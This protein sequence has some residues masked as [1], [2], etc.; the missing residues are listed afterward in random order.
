MSA[1]EDAD[2][3]C[4]AWGQAPLAQQPHRRITP[5]I[6]PRLTV[7]GAVIFLALSPILA[8]PGS[9]PQ[10]FGPPPLAGA[11][12]GAQGTSSSGYPVPSNLSYCGLLGPTPGTAPGLPNY[13]ANITAFWNDLCT[14]P[15]FISVIDKWGG[16]FF[17]AWP[18]YGAN[19]S[20]WAAANFSAGN[21]GSNEILY[22]IFEVNW[23]QGW[24][25]GNGSISP[26]GG[27]LYCDYQEYWAGE[28]STNVLT[29]P[30]FYNGSCP[31]CFPL[32]PLTLAS[33]SSPGFPYGPV[34]G[35]SF[36]GAFLVGVVIRVR[37][38]G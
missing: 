19:M 6:I 29:G 21:L 12:T 15:A 9:P 37:H 8:G 22:A 38:S 20:Y 31:T 27:G 24:C 1:Y 32:P 2:R 13:T 36:A 3:V 16:P 25:Y 34:L 18:G 33:P 28:V 4:T 5:R 26:G 35:F 10:R 11:A 17:L 7:L 14:R 30:Y 23:A